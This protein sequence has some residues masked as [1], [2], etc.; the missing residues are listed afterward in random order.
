[1]MSPH[2]CHLQS[3]FGVIS[4]F[5]ILQLFFAFL[6]EEKFSENGWMVYNPM[7]EYRRQ[8]SYYSCHCLVLSSPDLH[9][10]IAVCT[11]LLSA[12]GRGW[13]FNLKKSKEKK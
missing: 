8:V 1:M 12:G 13:N 9:R 6:N 11:F 10:G 3:E 4:F 7:S 5:Y 2:I